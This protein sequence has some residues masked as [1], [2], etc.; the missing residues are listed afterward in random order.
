MLQSTVQRL[1]DNLE[2][3][4][5]VCGEDH[6]FLVAEQLRKNKVKHNG[7]LL[8]P[9]GRNT[10]PAIAIAALHTMATPNTEDPLLV[11]LPADHLIA[12]TEAFR[13]AIEAAIPP[14]E[15]GSLITFGVVPTCPETGYGYIKSGS[16]QGA[17]YKVAEFVEKPD[18]ATAESYLDS[19]DYYWN[20]GMFLF[21][22]S[23]YLQELEL[24]RPD[25]FAA[26][27]KAVE[28][29]QQDNDFVRVGRDEFAASPSDSIDYAVMEKASD[30]QMLP[31][32]C[33]WSDLGSWSALWDVSDKDNQGNSSDG[34][35]IF[36]NSS[37]CLIRSDGKLVATVGLNDV[38][39]VDT[40]DATLVASKEHAQDVKNIVELLKKGNIDCLK[41]H[42]K[43]Y[44]PWGNY[45]SVDAGERFQVKRIVVNPGAELSLQ[46][47]HHRAEHWIVV[48]GTALVT[49]GEEEFLVTENQST[50]IPLGVKHRL[51]N[52]GGIPLEIIEVQSGSYLGED[53]IVR[54][55]DHYGR[56][57]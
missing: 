16:Q 31:L 32:D 40:V 17:A 12:D 35:V 8:E 26:C 41:N 28:N 56:V 6:R 23:R 45:D 18:L 4:I 14:A 49:K 9:V 7:I 52:P 39:V 33:G 24:H 38:I 29:C 37:N 5:V 54:F 48:K 55:E 25:I 44:R 43:V 21:R 20:S 30:I 2:N 51:K 50:F 1:G 57:V 19:G 27:K 53:D 15:S 11:V 42:R 10:A 34:E 46:M 36:H 13:K 22:V 3:P 47:H